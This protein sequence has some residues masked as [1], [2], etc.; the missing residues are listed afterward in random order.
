MTAY[1][2][3]VREETS[4]PAELAMY[5]Q[6]VAQSLEGHKMTPLAAYGAFE[7]LEGPPME[8]A[9]ILQFATMDE[10]RAWYHSPAYQEVCQHRFAGAKYRAFLI[11]GVA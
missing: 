2:V 6:K 4:N 8:G 9:V 1:A 7:L 5:S 10:A 3:F 11:E